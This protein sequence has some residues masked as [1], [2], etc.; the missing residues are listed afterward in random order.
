MVEVG[1]SFT[2]R[3]LITKNS[4]PF[5]FA[6]VLFI[7]G[8]VTGSGAIA[9]SCLGT[10]SHDDRVAKADVSFD[11]LVSGHW[12]EELPYGEIHYTFD[13]IKVFKAPNELR[14]F[15]IKIKPDSWMD[16]FYSCGMEIKSNT[17]YRIYAYENEGV[18][19]AAMC[20]MSVL[21][22]HT[23]VFKAKENTVL[24]RELIPNEERAISDR[25]TKFGCEIPNYSF[26][27]AGCG[28][29]GKD[30]PVYCSGYINTG[31]F[32]IFEISGE[33][34]IKFKLNTKT[35]EL[36]ILKRHGLWLDARTFCK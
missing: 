22:D 8:S 10:G 24:P 2:M 12:F 3:K 23:Y 18:L 11:G 26:H 9:C 4:S 16:R 5:T 25:L 17:L 19:T 34:E 13:A 31:H 28:I 33:M 20:T 1:P 14:I 36:H 30:G 6:V 21:N 32:D 29:E 15:D 7:L 27:Q 35:D